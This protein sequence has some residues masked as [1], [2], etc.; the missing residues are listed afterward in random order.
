MAEQAL[1]N[2]LLELKE[3]QAGSVPPAL[4]LSMEDLVARHHVAL[5]RYAY[6]L[7]GNQP[8]ACDLTQ[9]AYVVAQQKIAQLRDPHA[10]QYWLCAILRNCFLKSRNREARLPLDRSDLDLL[11]AE[12]AHE[13]VD[14]ER[15]QW[16]LN[17]LAEEQRVVV[18][19]F[20]FENLSYKEI[21]LALEIPVGTVMSRLARAKKMLKNKLRASDTLSTQP[22]QP[23]KS[24]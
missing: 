2:K 5:Y 16:A 7:S 12:T 18:L 9:Q 20:Y 11:P 1:A 3:I 10:A 15:L 13:S 24:T 17:G 21:A 14:G 22:A 19:M 8:D 6:R 4:V 23:S